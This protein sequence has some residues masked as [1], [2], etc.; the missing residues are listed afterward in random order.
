VV[1]TTPKVCYS[2]AEL[3]AELALL[4][5][6]CGEAPSIGLALCAE[7]GLR[8]RLWRDD[9]TGKCSVEIVEARDDD[10]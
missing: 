10:V 4:A 1:P 2:T 6:A 9:A 8:L 5:E 7:S 3:A